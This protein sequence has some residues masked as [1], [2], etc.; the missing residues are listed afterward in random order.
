MGIAVGA[1]VGEG[2]PTAVIQS[3]VGAGRVG[4]GAGDGGVGDQGDRGGD[5][6]G[7]TCGLAAG[8]AG[9]GG[10]SAALEGQGLR[11]RGS[12]NT[13]ILHCGRLL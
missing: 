3:A 10:G 1:I 9:A 4:R 8:W 12:E 5:G 6:G 11:F 13:G 2:A 7:D